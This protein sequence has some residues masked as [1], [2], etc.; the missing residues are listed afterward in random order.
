MQQRRANAFLVKSALT[1][2]YEGKPAIPVAK[3]WDELCVEIPASLAADMDKRLILA[4]D[5]REAVCEAESTGEVFVLA[6][7]APDGGEL[8]QCRLV[9]DV[10]TTWVQ[11]IKHGKDRFAVID[12]WNHRMRFSDKD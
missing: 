3:P 5:L 10:V 2:L 4:D 12:A 9:R 7:G 1:E 11:Y 8:R 6:G